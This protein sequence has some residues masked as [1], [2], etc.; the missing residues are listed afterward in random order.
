MFYLRGR[1]LGE[2]NDETVET[3]LGYNYSPI[4]S[5]LLLG[6]ASPPL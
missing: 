3:A 2:S 4:K 6:K 1:R 5:P